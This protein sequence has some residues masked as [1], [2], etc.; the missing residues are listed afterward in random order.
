MEAMLG[1]GDQI[2]V[3]T[4]KVEQVLVEEFEPPLGQPGRKVALSMRVEFTASYA[5][6]EDLNEL[7]NT[8]LNASQPEEYV[9]TGD[10]LSFETINSHRTDNKGVTRWTIRVSRQ[11]EK[12][13]DTGKIISLVQ[14]HDIAIAKEKLEDNLDLPYA[15][16]IQL[17]PDWWPW[18][19]LIP[20]NITVETR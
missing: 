19:P 3:N 9:D 18:L 1:P 13:V 15:P 8:V 17:T 11:L 2:F 16:E 7:A 20:F 10:P 5:A 12:Q 14:G 4:L 6:G